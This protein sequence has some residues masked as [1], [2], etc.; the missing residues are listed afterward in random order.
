LLQIGVLRF[1]VFVASLK[2]R[3]LLLENRKLLAQK[4]DMLCLN[5]GGTVFLDE[6]LQRREEISDFHTSNENKLSDGHRE[7]ASLE[8]KVF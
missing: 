6:P 2:L 8:V 5:R 7:R 1:K 3:K 4:R